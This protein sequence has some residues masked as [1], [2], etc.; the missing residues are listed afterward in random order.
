MAITALQMEK[1]LAIMN[2]TV[3]HTSDLLDG[4]TKQQFREASG[5]YLETLANRVDLQRVRESGVEQLSRAE[6]QEI[7][8]VNADRL[9][10]RAQEVRDKEAG[11][12]A[13]AQNAADRA[14]EAERRKEAS[15]GTGPQALKAIPPERAAVSASQQ[16]AAREAR[17]GAAAI[18]VTRILA[19]HPAQ[20]IPASLVQTDA[21]AKLRSE[22]DKLID[23]LE[24]ERLK[25]ESLGGQRIRGSQ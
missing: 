3:S 6:L 11:E 20:P 22:Q 23:Q 10:Q 8:G 14:I 18:E 25:G 13:A 4:P 9:I 16:S 17:E 21:L 2:E 12:A 19:E 5:R 24:A 15:G 1:D 7:V